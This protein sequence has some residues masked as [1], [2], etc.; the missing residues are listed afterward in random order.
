MKYFKFLLS[1]YSLIGTCNMCRIA[2]SVTVQEYSVAY[3][4]R[5]E[6]LKPIR[7][8]LS[9]YSLIRASNNVQNCIHSIVSVG[10][11]RL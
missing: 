4:R 2:L 10:V 1:T 8:L 3:L 9:P 7:V 6:T 11:D 5:R